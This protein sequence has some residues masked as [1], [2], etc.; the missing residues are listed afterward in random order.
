M[1]TKIAA[2]EQFLVETKKHNDRWIKKKAKQDIKAHPQP[3]SHP[4]KSN[5]LYLKEN[6]NGE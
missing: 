1:T 5:H 6:K 2:Y 3:A 4:W